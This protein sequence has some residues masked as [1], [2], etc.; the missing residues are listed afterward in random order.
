MSEPDAKTQGP[1]DTENAHDVVAAPS[2]SPPRHR[3]SPSPRHPS[4]TIFRLTDL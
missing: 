2:D 3:V 1:G 4:L